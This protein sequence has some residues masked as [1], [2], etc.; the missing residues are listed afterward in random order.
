MRARH[1]NSF[2][3]LGMRE[4]VAIA[5]GTIQITSTPHQGTTVVARFTLQ[6]AGGSD[7]V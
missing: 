5:G 7:D 4:R 6:A 2:G 1:G 3:L